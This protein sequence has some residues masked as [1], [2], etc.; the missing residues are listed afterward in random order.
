MGMGGFRMAAVGSRWPQQQ[1]VLLAPQT[2]PEV[3][4]AR[5]G[6]PGSAARQ[7]AGVYETV[8]SQDCSCASWGDLTPKY[9]VPPQ[10]GQPEHT[11]CG[12]LGHGSPTRARLSPPPAWT[13]PRPPTAP[14]EGGSGLHP[15][16]V[17]NGVLRTHGSEG[18][19]DKVCS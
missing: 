16:L 1:F 12:G 15:L 13:L 8:G 10:G 9:H 11:H 19:A 6:C 7:P 14:S 2:L 5:P 4:M 17:T 18:H 3:D